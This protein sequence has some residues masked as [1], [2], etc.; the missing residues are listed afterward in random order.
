MHTQSNDVWWL[1]WGR[2]IP[3]ATVT[4]LRHVSVSMCLMCPHTYCLNER[5]GEQ[6]DLS[7]RRPGATYRHRDRHRAGRR[8]RECGMTTLAGGVNSD[9]SLMDEGR[10]GGQSKEEGNDFQKCKVLKY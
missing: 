7:L 4:L 8:G 9:C 1:L 3:G 2:F 10:G 6:V 5:T